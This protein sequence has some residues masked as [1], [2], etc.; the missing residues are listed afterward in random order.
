MLAN[1]MRTHLCLAAS[2]ALVT[3]LLGCSD[4]EDD[5]RLAR[6]T[7]RASEVRELGF[8][9]EVPIRTI[10]SD[11]Y[12][13]EVQAD[14]DTLTDAELTELAETYG[15][16]GFFDESLDLRPIL[17]ASNDWPVATYDHAQKRITLIG[18]APDD[19]VVHELVHALQDQHFDLSSYRDVSTS[20]AALSRSSVVEGDASL[21]Q[22]R[23]YVEENYGVG[24]DRLDWDKYLDA[25][26]A[27]S[28]GFLEGSSVPLVFAAYPAFAYAYG[29]LFCASQLTGVT[30]EAPQPTLPAPYLWAREDA[31]FGQIAPNATA[32]IVTLQ[33]HEGAR[34]GL[35]EVPSGLSCAL[36]RL[37]VDTL[38]AFYTYLLTYPVEAEHGPARAAALAEAWAG[39]T[40]LFV[41]DTSNGEA[42]LVWTSAWNEGGE[43]TSAASLAASLATL[44]GVSAD[45]EEPR[46]GVAADGQGVWLEAAGDRV[47]LVKNVPDACLAE[48]AEAALSGVAAKVLPPRRSRSL[49]DWSR[50]LLRE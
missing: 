34:P 30:Q 24:L 3:P 41:R 6:L 40:L 20:D 22:T 12:L 17:T 46:K 38:G 29:G 33:G 48:L 18:D 47:V 35:S 44:H 43:G 14:V 11:Q 25:R 31:L 27:Q 45:A 9:E 5:P 32:T 50:R 19:V 37:E 7:L 39:D 15:R 21:A 49:G 4:A 8:L 1:S 36:E 2:F 42:G 10:T 13:A 16:L 28:E 26:F 23:F